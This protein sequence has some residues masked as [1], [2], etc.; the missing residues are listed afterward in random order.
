MKFIRDIVLPVLVLVGVTYT[1][2]HILD[3]VSRESTTITSNENNSEFIDLNTINDLDGIIPNYT[4][5]S[6][7]FHIAYA[8]KHF[9]SKCPNGDDNID[10]GLISAVCYMALEINY[11]RISS[12]GRDSLCN[13]RAGGSPGSMHKENRAVDLSIPTYYE[14]YVRDSMLYD[15]NNKHVKLMNKEWGV[16]GIGLSKKGVLHIDTNPD[17]PIRFWDYKRRNSNQFTNNTVEDL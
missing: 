5:D 17:T 9:H 4:P 11:A 13:A 3:K 10:I 16:T 7:I 6:S 8:P 15:P 1:I 2:I 14:K 12:A